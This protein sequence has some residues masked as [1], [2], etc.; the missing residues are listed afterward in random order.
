M[1]QRPKRSVGR[2]ERVHP[3]D[4]YIAYG[5]WMHMRWYSM[6]LRK[7]ETMTFKMYPLKMAYG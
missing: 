3:G 4:H 2:V 7:Q 1:A 6:I 5:T